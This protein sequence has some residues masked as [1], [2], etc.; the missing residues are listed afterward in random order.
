MLQILHPIGIFFPAMHSGMPED[1]PRPLR[2]VHRQPPLPPTTSLSLTSHCP[3]HP[4]S[5]HP[6]Q[7]GSNSSIQHTKVLFQRIEP[8][9]RTMFWLHRLSLGV[10]LINLAT[11]H[12]GTLAKILKFVRWR[13]S[14]KQR[15]K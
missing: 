10:L 15:K 12:I 9:T 11:A 3:L 14:V 13:W 1:K 5:L 2:S 7:S 6:T 4:S 8:S